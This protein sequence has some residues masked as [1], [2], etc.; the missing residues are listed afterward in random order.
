MT[1]DAP[2]SRSGRSSRP[3]ADPESPPHENLPAPGPALQSWFVYEY[4]QLRPES[5]VSWGKKKDRITY[6]SDD[7]RVSAWLTLR[8]VRVALLRRTLRD[9]N[10]P[11]PPQ[12]WLMADKPEI[13][14]A[15]NRLLVV[16]VKVSPHPAVDT[17]ELTRRV[18]EAAARLEKNR[19]NARQRREAKA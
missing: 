16:E 8:F 10:L 17:E 11:R 18:G 13:V 2:E 5:L 19:A 12:F 14:L 1:P 15:T 6:W 4:N 3:R 7:E 9:L